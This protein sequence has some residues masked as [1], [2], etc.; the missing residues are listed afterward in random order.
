MKIVHLPPT[1]RGYV[2]VGILLPHVVAVEEAVGTIRHLASRT[3]L[4]RTVMTLPA[5]A[6]RVECRLMMTMVKGGRKGEGRW[7]E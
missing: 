7:E 3:H 4:G 2:V 5:P 6:Y 1:H